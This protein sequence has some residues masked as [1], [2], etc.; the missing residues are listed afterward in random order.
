MSKYIIFFLLLSF[1][2]YPQ[3]KEKK[4]FLRALEVGNLNVLK[5]KFNSNNFDINMK[6]AQENSII[7]S[8]LKNKNYKNDLLIKTLSFFLNFLPSL[9]EYDENLDTPLLLLIKNNYIS[10]KEK[11]NLMKIMIEKGADVMQKNIYGK[12]ALLCSIENKNLDIVNYLLNF[13]DSDKDILQEKDIYGNDIFFYA[14]KSNNINIVNYIFLKFYTKQKNSNKNI[15]EYI[16]EK[17]NNVRKEIIIFLRE[18]ISDISFNEDNFKND[19]ISINTNFKKKEIDH[20]LVS[21][22]MTEKNKWILIDINGKKIKDLGEYDFI[23]RF[24]NGIAIV[25][26]GVK[27]GFLSQEK[28]LI[29]KV[30]YDFVQNF[31]KNGVAVVSSPLLSTLINKEGKNI[32]PFKYDII[33]DISEGVAPAYRDNN[34]YLISDEGKEIVKLVYSETKNMSSGLIPVA[35][36]KL[37]GYITPEL[38]EIIPL[39]YQ[40]AYPFSDDLA[41]V[42]KNDKYGFIDKNNNMVIKNIYD[43][44]FS[45]SDGRALVRKD[46]KYY[47]IN[48]NGIRIGGYL[49]YEYIDDFKNGYSRVKKN[50]KWGFLNKRIKQA[51]P[52]EYD[53][54]STFSN[55]IA[56]V[57]KNGGSY[58][59]DEN[60]NIVLKEHYLD[61]GGF[62]K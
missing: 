1:N 14:V 44:A 59:I 45:F 39:V 13:Y 7:V 46:K 22:V 8:I 41:L 4:I 55:G 43:S 10:Q 23:G 28:G 24:N 48:I 19:K 62:S 42:K 40:D 50:N 49:E 37:W 34:W 32:I 9:K 27:Y 16:K 57:K 33:R 36:N 5:S 35:N 53:E 31:S 3:D 38:I 20:S 25:K 11:L 61:A 58:F 29:T 18:Y 6:D 52:L 12:N 17:S 54:V 60:N 2:I 26:K 15:I 56:V 51:I 30:Q 21:A 47:F